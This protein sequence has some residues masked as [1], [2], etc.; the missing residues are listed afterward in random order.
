MADALLLASTRVVPA[1]LQET[2][3]KFRFSS[4]HDALSYSLGVDRLESV[5]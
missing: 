4:L 5:E 2:D 3:Y 1:K